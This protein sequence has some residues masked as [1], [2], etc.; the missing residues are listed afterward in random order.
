VQLAGF[1][2]P[3]RR[4]TEEKIA[5]PELSKPLRDIIDKK[6]LD[7]RRSP[8]I[9]PKPPLAGLRDALLGQ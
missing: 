8:R 7:G 6:I 5:S 3:K 4:L 1:P 2:S 9:S